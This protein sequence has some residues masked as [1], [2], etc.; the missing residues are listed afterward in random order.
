ML[1]RFSFHTVCSLRLVFLLSGLAIAT[2][3][4]L[5]WPLGAEVLQTCGSW[6]LH[7]LLMTLASSVWFHLYD[8]CLPHFICLSPGR[9]LPMPAA[10][11]QQNDNTVEKAATAEHN[12]YW[13]RCRGLHCGSQ[14]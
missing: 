11:A 14:H 9:Y 2:S 8:E 10:K 7:T 12:S 5:H 13:D 1:P 3:T 6:P 4:L